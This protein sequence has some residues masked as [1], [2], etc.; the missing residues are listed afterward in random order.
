MEY[1]SST[2]SL[3]GFGLGTDMVPL[4]FRLDIATLKLGVIAQLSGFY[5]IENGISA[6]DASSETLYGFTRA[7]STSAATYSVQVDVAAK[8]VTS[9]TPVCTP[10]T[11]GDFECPFNFFYV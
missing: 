5:S 9:S 10:K 6:W 1:Q 7:N 8:K 2:F 11:A 3:V 4:A